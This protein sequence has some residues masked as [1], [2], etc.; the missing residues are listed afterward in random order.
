MS[1]VVS[2]F[3]ADIDDESLTERRREMLE[4][5]LIS[6]DAQRRRLLDAS[7]GGEYSSAALRTALAELDAD[8]LS[9]ERRLAD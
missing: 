5:Q 7:A 4:L 1:G 6:L 8:Q 2:R 9:I 3:T